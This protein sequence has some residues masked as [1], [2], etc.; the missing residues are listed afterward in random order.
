M[1]VLLSGRWVLDLGFGLYV[2]SPLHKATVTGS[3][4]EG[5]GPG[6]DRTWGAIGY[7][8]A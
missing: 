5:M 6:W 4:A 2:S 3:C 8:D 7:P 1:P